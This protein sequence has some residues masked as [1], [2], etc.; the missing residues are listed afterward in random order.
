L[1]NVWRFPYIA[2]RYGGAAFVVLYLVFL[3]CLAMPVMVMEFSVG[4]ASQRS[5]IKSFKVL[6]PKGTFWSVF[7]YF[8]LAGNYI[9]MMFYTTVTGWMLSYTWYSLTGRLE[10]LSSDQAGALFGGLL[11][12]PVALT[13]W[14]FVAVGLGS[15]ICI[16]G[17]QKGVERATKVMMCGLLII[18]VT[19]AVRSVTLPGAEKGLEFYLKPDFGRLVENGVWN[20]IYAALGQSVFTLS[21]GVGSMAI[22][23]SYIGKERSLLGESVIVTA[24][25]TFVALSAGLIIFPACFAYN[26]EPN[27][28]PGLI[29]VTLPNMF[30][31]MPK[32][33]IWGTLFFL[34]MSFAAMTTVVATFELLIAASMETLGWSRKKA[35]IVNFFVI[36]I[37]SLPCVFGFNIWSSFAPLGEGTIVL[38]L[39]DFI[40]S[41]N[42]LPIGC[43]VYLLFCCSR[44]GWGWDNFTAEANAGKGLKVARALRPYFTYVV[45]AAIAIILI[46][47]YIDKFFS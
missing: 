6:Q 34:F 44:Y 24:L 29:F 26:I 3:L 47:G 27:A 21:L 9:L 18:M 38:D 14:L 32:G 19:L 42:L 5:V 11:A 22:F 31:N 17:L 33:R 40:V 10:G 35:S 7:G 13:F 2:G 25:D 20:S 8:G 23:G 1:G 39:E 28:G 45:P 41:N 36:F 15:L 16:V 46:F 30:N 37:F 12:D 4:R 43:I